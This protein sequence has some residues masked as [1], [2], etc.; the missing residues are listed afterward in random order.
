VALDYKY[1][2][3]LEQNYPLESTGSVP[4]FAGIAIAKYA[5]FLEQNYHLESTGSVPGFAGIA[6]AIGQ[7]LPINPSEMPDS[8]LLAVP[9]RPPIRPMSA[10]WFLIHAAF[11]LFVRGSCTPFVMAAAERDRRN[12]RLEANNSRRPCARP[13]RPKNRRPFR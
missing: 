9:F 11:S 3:F 8:V 1:A 10:F 5:G 12:A 2:G 6:I 4:G 7:R 13:S